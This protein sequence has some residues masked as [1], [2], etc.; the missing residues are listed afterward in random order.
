MEI[1]ARRFATPALLLVLGVSTWAMVMV[2]AVSG[3]ATWLFI[4]SGIAVLYIFLFKAPGDPA[5]GGQGSGGASDSGS[6][7]GGFTGGSDCGGGHGGGDGG[8]GC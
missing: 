8:G 5:T 3:I 2:P 7:F 6:G 1:R 4:L